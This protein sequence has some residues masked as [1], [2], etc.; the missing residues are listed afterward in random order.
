M[1]TGTCHRQLISVSVAPIDT[2]H[3]LDKLW[4]WNVGVCVNIC[5]HDGALR[6][7]KKLYIRLCA[8]RDNTP[9][10]HRGGSF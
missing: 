2:C 9:N 8:A 1:Y 5:M 7:V 10:R 6:A 3:G 4:K